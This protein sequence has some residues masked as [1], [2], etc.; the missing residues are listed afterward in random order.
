MGLWA[1]G[2][3]SRGGPGYF[4]PNVALGSRRQGWA[5]SEVATKTA[6]W[7][8]GVGVGGPRNTAG[9]GEATSASL[10]LLPQE[11]PAGLR[12]PMW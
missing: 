2:Q 5:G 12:Q 9:G 4:R 1:A 10:F 11:A 7:G 6:S 3:K 8:E